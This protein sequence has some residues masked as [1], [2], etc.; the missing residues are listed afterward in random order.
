MRIS[1]IKNSKNILKDAVIINLP[2]ALSHD[3]R[4]LYRYYWAAENLQYYPLKLLPLT[5]PLSYHQKKILYGSVF[6]VINLD[7]SYDQYFQTK[8]KSPERALIRKA[9]KNGF[10]IKRIEYDEYISEIQLINTSKDVRCGRSMGDD[11]V[12]VCK[13]DEIISPLN[14]EIYTYGCFSESGELVAYYVFEHFTNFFHTVKGIGHSDFLNMGIMNYLFAYCAS[15]L[16][17]IYK[18]NV[19]V[20]GLMGSDGL[21]RFKKNVGCKPQM[22]VYSGTKD[23]FRYLEYFNENFSLHGDTA[24]NFVREYVGK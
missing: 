24:L 23:D 17:Q 7:F 18:D 3:A 12:H 9:I 8:I 14:N 6:S 19:L 2:H 10:T 11:Y 22:I 4:N 13:R 20:Y 15:E 21:S 16:G 5:L 1:F